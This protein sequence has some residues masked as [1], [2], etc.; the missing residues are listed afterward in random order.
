VERCKPAQQRRVAGSSGPQACQC[1]CTTIWRGSGKPR[2]LRG[3]TSQLAI[4]SMCGKNNFQRHLLLDG[5]IAYC[6]LRS[7]RFDGCGTPRCGASEH[8][9]LPNATW[10]DHPIK[11]ARNTGRSLLPTPRSPQPRTQLSAAPAMRYCVDFPCTKRLVDSPL[12]CQI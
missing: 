1:W 3:H 8:A 2:P 5:S 10:R 6:I 12:G 4:P 7:H 11:P 9:A